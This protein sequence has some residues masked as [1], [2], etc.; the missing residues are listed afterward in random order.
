MVIIMIPL[1]VCESI[2]YSQSSVRK[3]LLGDGIYDY[4]IPFYVRT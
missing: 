2:I 3:Y 1:R 4:K